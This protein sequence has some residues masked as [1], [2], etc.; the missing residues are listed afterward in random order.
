MKLLS[1]R[2]NVDAYDVGQ[3]PLRNDGQRVVPRS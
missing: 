1:T 3:D 2:D